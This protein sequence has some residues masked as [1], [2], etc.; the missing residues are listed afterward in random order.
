[1]YPWWQNCRRLRRT[2]KLLKGRRTNWENNILKRYSTRWSLTNSRNGPKLLHMLSVQ[3][4]IAT[5]MHSFDNTPNLK[6]W[7]WR[8]LPSWMT[9]VH[10]N[11]LSI[12]TNW[13]LPC[14]NIVKPIFPKQ[15]APHLLS[16]HSTIFCNMMVSP[17]TETALLKGNLL[18]YMNLMNPLAP[19]SNT[20]KA[21]SKWIHLQYIPWIM[22][23]F[24]MA[25]RN[26]PNALLCPHLDDILKFIKIGETCGW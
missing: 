10:N 19:Y 5:A 22:T 4:V 3:N 17:C 21:K 20:F 25:S 1:M 26:G 8:I 15:K 9:L 6:H 14:S 11:L 12:N 18:I 24:W 23:H 16:T 13:N 2:K 7:G